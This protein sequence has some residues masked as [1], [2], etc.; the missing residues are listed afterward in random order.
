LGLPGEDRI[1]ILE[2]A[3]AIAEMGLD[4][5]KLHLLY[6]VK[7]TRL[8]DLYIQGNYR[9][10]EQAEYVELVCEFLELLPQKMVIHR[11]TGDPHPTELVEPH[12]ALD[13]YATLDLIKKRFKSCH[14][15]QGKYYRQT[16]S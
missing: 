13:K 6:V 11:L 4:G 8:H 16:F 2:S 5:I 3:K 15:Y 7:G 14:S 12:W 9:C 10:L 1:K